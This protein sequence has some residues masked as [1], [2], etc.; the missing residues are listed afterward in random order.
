MDNY[1]PFSG[2]MY[3]RMPYVE[4]VY[5]GARGRFLCAVF[6]ARAHSRRNTAQVERSSHEMVLHTGT[7]LDPPTSDQHDRVFLGVVA[8]AGDIRRDG[9]ARRQ[10]YPRNLA[11]GRIRFLGL[12]RRHFDADALSEGRAHERGR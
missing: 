2:D 9:L 8:F 6:T 1:G 10:L 4:K 12:F 7:V 3:R 11:H 5:L